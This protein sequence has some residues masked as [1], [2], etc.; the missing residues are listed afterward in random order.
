[1]GAI[2]QHEDGSPVM[3][4]GKLEAL[5]H[6][7]TLTKPEAEELFHRVANGED[8]STALQAI[9]GA[10]VT[11]RPAVEKLANPTSNPLALADKRKDE[12]E[13]EEQERAAGEEAATVDKFSPEGGP[14]GPETSYT[15]ATDK[16]G[17][18]TRASDV[19]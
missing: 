13:A 8:E 4:D 18:V 10:R 17:N 6:Q 16:R 2:S 1:M 9:K 12:Q 3:T 14:Y 11:Y 5:Q 19:R 15:D 7:H